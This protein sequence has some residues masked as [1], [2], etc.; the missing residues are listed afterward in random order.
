MGVKVY[1][2]ANNAKSHPQGTNISVADGH[3]VVGRSQ[4]VIAIY[5]PGSWIRAEEYVDTK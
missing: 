3:L 4:T 2:S 1:V 5:A